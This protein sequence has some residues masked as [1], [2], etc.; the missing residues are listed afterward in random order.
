MSIGNLITKSSATIWRGLMV[1][2]ALDKLMR[3]VDW[4]PVDYM[5]ID[6]PPGTGDT[7]L[8]LIQNTPITGKCYDLVNLYRKRFSGA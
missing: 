3:Q 5:I 6:T 1:M 8:S 7:H 4:D 2:N